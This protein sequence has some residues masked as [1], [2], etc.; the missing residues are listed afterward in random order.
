VITA[1]AYSSIQAALD[2][3]P[4]RMI[5]VPD[6]DYRLTN[7][8]VIR[9]SGS[10][11]YGFGRLIQGNTDAALIE[12]HGAADVRLRD[13]TLTRV[14]GSETARAPAVDAQDCTGLSIANLRVLD[15][16]AAASAIS[17]RQCPD[18]QITCCVVENYSTLGIDDR[19]GSPHYG[20]AFNCIDG[21]GIGASAC[22]GL[23]IQGNRVIE[24]RMRPTPELKARYKLGQFVKGAPQKC[25]LI[26]QQTWDAGY[27]NNLQQGSAI[28]VTGPT[29]SR[30][31]RVLN[32]HIENAAQGID[33]HADNVIVSGNLVVNSFIGMKAIHGSRNVLI[34]NNQFIRN[35]L[36]AIGLMPG[37]GSHAA[38][39]ATNGAPAKAA[40]ADG[41]HVVA[42]NIISDFGH[43][44]S[45]WIW[46][47]GGFTR[48]PILFD[49]GQEADDPPLR[50]VV[51]AGNIIRNPPADTEATNAAQ[52]R[53]RYAV[54][55]DSG[56]AGPKG[57]HFHGNLFPPGRDGISNVELRP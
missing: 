33:L 4:G 7:A 44:D 11:L 55:I 19:T 49:R 23:L 52:A 8:I 39:A 56:P 54:W 16:R 51:I 10:G 57:L 36:W 30:G 31:V 32:N 2:A 1:A 48:A 29:E 13:L 17:L 35:D 15:N 5:F 26:S 21:T 22:P 25:S 14:A 34:A 18:A 12:M 37:T 43:G 42:N 3:N 24:R 45:W 38:L 40:N 47:E 50:D 27:V 6:G 20:Y 46:N 41:G 53:Y 28:A 9:R